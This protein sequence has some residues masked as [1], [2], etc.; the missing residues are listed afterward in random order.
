MS[1]VSGGK[2]LTSKV[3]AMITQ[4]QLKERLH[5]EP[6]TGVFT[7]LIG[8]RQGQVVGFNANDGYM[9]ISPVV[10][11]GEK[12]KFYVLHRMAWFCVNGFWPPE[13]I[14]HINGD[15]SDNRICNLRLASKFQDKINSI[16]PSDAKGAARNKLKQ[17]KEKMGGQNSRQPPNHTRMPLDSLHGQFRRRAA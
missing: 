2:R 12:P 7:W 3:E 4:E 14:D 1:R 17:S 16:R 9:Q 15:R 11:R 8:Q 13:E 10:Q 6:E 5:Y